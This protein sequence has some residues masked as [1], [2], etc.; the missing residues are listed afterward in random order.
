MKNRIFTYSFILSLLLITRFINGHAQINTPS[1]A[2]M[3][4]GA[5]TDYAYGM[6]PS[7]L[8]SGGQYGHAQAAA[9][10]YESIT[11]NWV[12]TCSDGTARIEWE[13]TTQTVSEGIAYGMLLS[14][15]AADKKLFDMLWQFY[16][17][18]TNDHGLMNWHIQGCSNGVVGSNGASDSE[19]DAAMALIIA[20]YQWPDA[21]FG[22]TPH[23]YD[24]DAISLIRKIAQY[25][26]DH[27]NTYALF[28]GDR[29]TSCWNPSYQAPSYYRCYKEFLLNHDVTTMPNDEDTETFWNKAIDAGETMLVNSS[30]DTS[31][32]A[33]NW[34]DDGLGS[35]CGGCAASN[36]TPCDFTEDAS[37]TPWRGKAMSVLWYNSSAMREVVN[38]QADFWISEGGAS[39][40]SGRAHDGS[41]DGRH[42]NTYIGPV[43]TLAMGADSTQEHQRFTDSM[44]AENVNVNT[45]EYFAQ[46]L[47]TLGLFVQTGQFWN[48]CNMTTNNSINVT[49]TSPSE[50][51]SLTDCDTSF[52]L[53]AEASADSGTIEVVE[54]YANGN[55]LCADSTSPYSCQWNNITTGESTVSAIAISNSN[56]SATSESRTISIPV[57]LFT[58][59]SPINIDGAIENQWDVQPALPLAHTPIG[60]VEDSSDLSAYFKAMYDNDSLYFLVDVT[61]D[62]TIRDS[63]G[64]FDDDGIEVFIDV[65]NDKNS[66]Y[67]EDDY[68]FTYSW[69]DNGNGDLTLNGGTFDDLSVI[70]FSKTDNDSGYIVEFAFSWSDIGLN[71]PSAGTELGLDIHVN[72]DDNG[73]GRDTK[74]AWND[75]SDIAH[76]DPSAFGMLELGT[77]PCSGEDSDG[78]GV[79]D[80]RDGCPEDSNK[81]EPG[82]CGCGDLDIDSDGD[83]TADCID[84]C[85]NDS[86][87]TEPGV[88]G[89]GTPDTDINNNDTIDCNEPG[90]NV[91]IASPSQDEALNECDQPL[92]VSAVVISNDYPVESVV[93]YANDSV[94]G[95]ATT[96]PYEVS[97]KEF[98]TGSHQL[99][100]IAIDSGGQRDSSAIVQVQVYES[101]YKL[102]ASLEIDGALDSVLT[103]YPYDSAN[104]TIVTDTSFAGS[105]IAAGF[106]AGWSSSHLYLFADITDDTLV[107]DGGNIYDNDGFEIYLDLGNEKSSGFDNNDYQLTYTWSDSGKGNMNV[108]NGNL[109]RESITYEMNT[110]NTGY[111][112]ELQI[113]WSSFARQPAEG[114]LIGFDFH[115]NDDDDGDARDKKITW[116][117]ENNNAWQDPSV[118][119]T[120][121]L[122]SGNCKPVDSDGDGVLDRNDGCPA[123]ANKTQ[124][125]ECGCGQTEESCL[126]CAGVPNGEAFIDSCGTCAGG[127]TGIEPVIDTS[128]CDP[129]HISSSPLT[130]SAVNVYPNPARDKVKVSL[131]AFYKKVEAKVSNVAGEL[132]QQQTFTN[133]NSF[134]L[135]IEGQAGMYIL[136]LKTGEGDLVRLKLLKE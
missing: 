132:I 33:P 2:T 71:D 100:A 84:E 81:T 104:Q 98:E 9:E 74:I 122:G 10:A 21:R 75:P 42:I 136:L 91:S 61:D 6:M 31:G 49:L 64:G 63:D 17:Q 43:G 59:S 123:D 133:T 41:G 39:I 116:R 76:Q 4:F 92:T 57:K 55:K 24:Q 45:P 67:G 101:M 108:T 134:D 118:F 13:D 83:G 12:D 46:M 29:F 130:R 117:D 40:V 27:Q 66:T 20:D 80:N 129:T 70:D 53:E 32:L 120:M 23:D 30:H 22:T 103:A 35:S 82:D 105:D 97:W 90:I 11:E 28:S 114:D 94:I 54:F 102:S 8:P 58:T 113:P 37:R 19:V 86:L 36:T 128:N 131:G 50:N 93:F 69:A 44:Y 3:P 14:A 51:T 47:R 89:C 124:P 79:D 16:K 26:I 73:G 109:N 107:S 135:N 60:S 56:G 127:T 18:N 95:E 38:T 112:V 1:G 65:G 115:V 62:T 88:C 111:A 7:N 48:P 5:N 110:H 125:G 87:K 126:D 68:Q 85:V 15:Y 96:Q 52:T 25:E 119:G 72:D 99:G 78:D 121:Q 34:S 77:V 106:K